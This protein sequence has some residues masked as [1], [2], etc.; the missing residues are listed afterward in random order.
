MTKLGL[1][2]S[3]SIAIDRIMTFSGKYRDLIQ[4]DKLHTFSISML[5]RKI[6]LSRGGTGANIAYNLARLGEQPILLGSVG[7]DGQEYIDDLKKEGVDTGHVHTSHHLQTASFNVIND[8]EDNQ[9]GGF[10]P[11]AMADSQMLNLDEWKGK[12]VLVTVSAH[13]PIGMSKQVYQCQEYGL[14]L[15]YDVSQQ[16]SNVSKENLVSG[17][18][19][20]EIII[21]NDYEMSLLSKKS[22]FSPSEIKNKVP[23]LIVTHGGKGSVI[24]GK[25]VKNP[26][27]VGVA[28]PTEVLD[29]TGAGD[30]Y[31]AGFLFGYARGWELEKCAKLGATVA[32]FIVE[33]YGSQV[34]YF[35]KDIMERYKQTF[36]EEVDI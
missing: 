6:E 1:I 19:A 8:S 16:V 30:A 11:G 17:I 31:R 12:N 2:I 32:S 10:Y 4:P 22:G 34:K 23:V 36:D 29:P 9:V 15:F 20:A 26:I 21:V 25:L 3:G 33:E 35:K 28:K 5:L 18:K 13:D 24:A 27:D 7:K 14:K